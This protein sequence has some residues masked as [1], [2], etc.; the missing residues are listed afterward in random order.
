MLRDTDFSSP[1]ARRALSG[2][3]NLERIL[4]A[5]CA[6]IWLAA[7]GAIVAAT[8]SLVDMA[9]GRGTVRA[10]LSE[11]SG[12]ETPWVLYTV[13]GISA[14][15]ILVAIP[16]LVRARQQSGNRPPRDH[17]PAGG[18][19]AE[20]I[21]AVPPRASGRRRA[22]P[23]PETGAR[24]A[25]VPGA[26]D[27]VFMRF[28]LSMACA[29]GA[30]TLAVGLATYLSAN[31]SGSAAVA[32]YIIAGIVTVAMPVLPWFYLRE[33]KRVVGTPAA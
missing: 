30:G 18:S 11:A 22:D 15:V 26:A 17:T 29:V 24:S 23:A 5:A 10:E 27:D 28:G 9:S 6:V 33:L 13:I 12:S 25:A 7:L 2:P 32:F 16:L 14:A 21:A 8:V 4:M 20:D 31:D 1:S 3:E 19:V